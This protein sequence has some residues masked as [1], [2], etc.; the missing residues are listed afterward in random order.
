MISM[1]PNASLLPRLVSKSAELFSKQFCQAA[2]PVPCSA[3]RTDF[4]MKILLVWQSSRL[5]FEKT[6]DLHG[7]F[8]TSYNKML[9]LLFNNGQ[10]IFV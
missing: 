4:G 2:R 9:G 10:N 5:Y 7:V 3:P 6:S 8:G 1:N